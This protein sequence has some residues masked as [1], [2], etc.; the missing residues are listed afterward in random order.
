MIDLAIIG[1]NNTD[2]NEF[3][4]GRIIMKTIYALLTFIG[5]A[6]P[7]SQFV[8]WLAEHGLNVGLF[9]Q[10]ITDN[11]LAVFAWLDVV[12]TVIVIV[13]M[14]MNDGK[15]LHMKKLWIPVLA[16]FIG[17][18]SVG[19]PLFLYMKQGHIERLNGVH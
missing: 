18:A 1:K 5:I 13:V 6:L 3:T 2:T 15:S 16:S 7:F 17:G 19:L 9:F 4:G 12:V 8:P 11:P 14:V 10:Q